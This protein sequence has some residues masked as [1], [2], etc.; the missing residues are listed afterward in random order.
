MSFILPLSLASLLHDS[1]GP[2][3]V[4]A[5]EDQER[6]AVFLFVCLFFSFIFISWV[7]ITL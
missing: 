1:L 5:G 7:L 4:K 6:K 3:Q 2:C